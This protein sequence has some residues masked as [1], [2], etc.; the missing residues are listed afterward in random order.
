MAADGSFT[1]MLFFIA[2]I[3]VAVSVSGVLI[4]VSNSMAQ[5][6]KVKAESTSD[7]MGTSIQFVNDPRHVPYEDGSLILYIKNVGDI[8]LNCKEIVIFIDGQYI[9]D[10]FVVSANN[11]WLVGEMIEIRA[12]ATLATG[13]HLA[14]ASMANGVSD[15]MDFRI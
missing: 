15:S 8:T 10:A 5:E 14:K 13:D 1:Q 2:A 6:L 4:G 11:N 7:Q 9:N 12:N 3:V